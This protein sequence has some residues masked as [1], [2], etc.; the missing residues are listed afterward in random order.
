MA[1]RREIAEL[2]DELTNEM[3]Q[4]CTAGKMAEAQEVDNQRTALMKDLDPNWP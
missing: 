3:S 4:L 1:D 2:V